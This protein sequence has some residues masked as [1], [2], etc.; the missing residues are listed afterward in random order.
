M[1]FA[2]LSKVDR[3]IIREAYRIHQAMLGNSDDVNR[4][5]AQTAEEVHVAWHEV[6]RLERTRNVLNSMYLPMFGSTS[7]DR[8]FD[9]ED[10]TPTSSNDANDELTSKSTAAA[11]LA[12]AGWDPE[13]VL[14]V[15]GLPPMAFTGPPAAALP[16]TPPGPGE[17]NPEASQYEFTRHEAVEAASAI[18]RGVRGALP[19]G[20]MSDLEAEALAGM[21]RET[22]NNHHN[23]HKE[24]V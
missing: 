16:G 10:P 12:K 8:E 23:G 11:V 13:E 24:R 15:V 21:I 4:A 20:E 17:G 22:F 1:Q 9:F 7:S 6:T 18:R 2:E 5:N 3:D 19:A 14:E